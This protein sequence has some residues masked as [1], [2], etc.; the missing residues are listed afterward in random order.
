MTLDASGEVESWIL[1]GTATKQHDVFKAVKF[2]PIGGNCLPGYIK[3]RI[4]GAL[5]VLL[6]SAHPT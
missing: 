2:L 6:Y 1:V 4:E 3:E 5:R